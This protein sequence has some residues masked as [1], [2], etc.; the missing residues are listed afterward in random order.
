MGH[1]TEIIVHG[2]WAE[3]AEHLRQSLDAFPHHC[4]KP[5]DPNNVEREWRGNFKSLDL[6]AARARLGAIPWE[7]PETIR[8]LIEDEDDEGF[9]VWV[10]RDGGLVL[11]LPPPM[12]G[13]QPGPELRT[14]IEVRGGDDCAGFG[15]YV[16]GS[17]RDGRPLVYLNLSAALLVQLLEG[18]SAREVIVETLMHEVGH[19]LEEWADLEY[20]DERLER[21]IDA[22]RERYGREPTL[23]SR[24]PLHR[25]PRKKRRR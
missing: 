18:V 17:M 15:G 21:M 25:R 12:T 20:S 13:R 7:S 6:E 11:A 9:G 24:G 8:I 2:A 23:I 19:A 4:L 16:V 1:W 22:Y 10:V 14:T 3:D 5:V